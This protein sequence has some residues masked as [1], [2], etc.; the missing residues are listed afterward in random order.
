MMIFRIFVFRAFVI[1]FEERF[2]T[3]KAGKIGN[4]G[5]MQIRDLLFC[6]LISFLTAHLSIE[7]F[8]GKICG[9][10]RLSEL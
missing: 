3:G 4:L 5:H 2:A 10:D 1:R 8:D 9:F 7:T 6:P